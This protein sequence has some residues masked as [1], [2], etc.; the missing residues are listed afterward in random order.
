MEREQLCSNCGKSVGESTYELH[1][2]HCLRFF[3]Q[4]VCGER[5]S[6]KESEAHL[7]S[8][9]LISECIYC[10]A[11]MEAYLLET[12]K[13]PHVI[14]ECPFCECIFRQIDYLDHESLCRIRTE[15]CHKC[16]SYIMRKDIKIHF[17]I[18][19]MP[20][21][22]D[23]PTQPPKQVIPKR[24]KSNNW[25]SVQIVK[26]EERF[27]MVSLRHEDF[28]RVYAE[29]LT[30]EMIYADLIKV[31]TGDHAIYKKKRSRNKK[32]LKSIQVLDSAELNR[33][34]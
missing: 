22:S 19:C 27:D 29:D 13:C 5:V 31:E 7:A 21:I 17:E 8:K 2:V 20:S 33:I 18:E 28:D 16:L 26:T 24:K 32:K 23:N 11:Q 30:E 34:T 12:H 14:I 4:C 3:I 1:V 15:Q 10:Q 6:V 9:H 25:Q